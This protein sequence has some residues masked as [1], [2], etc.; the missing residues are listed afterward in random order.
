MHTAYQIRRLQGKKG[1]F[2][3]LDFRLKIKTKRNQQISQS[4]IRNQQSEIT[5]LR[6]S[7]VSK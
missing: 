2:E 4:A 5:C 6:V 3:I 1:I 7:V